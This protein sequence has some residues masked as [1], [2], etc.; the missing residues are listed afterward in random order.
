MS[1]GAGGASGVAAGV[2][3]SCLVVLDEGPGE[4]VGT[5]VGTT[6]GVFVGLPTG[7]STGPPVSS[8]EEALRW[9]CVVGITSVAVPSGGASASTAPGTVGCVG[10][11]LAVSGSSASSLMVRPAGGVVPVMHAGY[12]L[13]G[14]A[15][16]VDAN[17]FDRSVS[18]DS[19]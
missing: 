5:A 8:V 19:R 2:T 12:V 4:S 9:R 16:L 6:S 18:V 13:C 1:V 7:H 10:L 15:N 3:S 11:M 17:L 14:D